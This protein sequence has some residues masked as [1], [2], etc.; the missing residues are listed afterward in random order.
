MK[1]LTEGDKR[2]IDEVML[3]F[4]RNLQHLRIVVGAFNLDGEF[5]FISDHARKTRGTKKDTLIGTKYKDLEDKSGIIV[6]EAEKIRL[7]VIE[8]K[9][10]I[11]YTLISNNIDPECRIE[12]PIY[13]AQ[14]IPFFNEKHEVIASYITTSPVTPLNLERIMF[15]KITSLSNPVCTVELSKRQH[16]ILFLLC[17][18]INQNKIAEYLG[19]TRGT[20]SKTIFEQLIPKFK[21]VYNIDDLV[22][23]ALANGV[24]YRFPPSLIHPKIFIVEH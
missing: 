2:L 22:N 19:V 8:T 5:I 17:Y 10:I 18:N 6:A 24:N 23:Q 11:S 15:N 12:F 21:N 13:T 14:H 16:E 4:L 20:V 3:P 1:Q 7:R 9:R